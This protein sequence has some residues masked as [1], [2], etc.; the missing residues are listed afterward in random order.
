MKSKNIEYQEKIDH[1]RLF[2]A[3]LVLMFHSMVTHFLW[4]PL[5]TD[6]IHCN[7]VWDLVAEGHMA[8]GLFMT[9]SG[10]LF[11]KI[12]RDKE[13]DIP[14]FYRNRFL[15]IYPLFVFAML[16][17]CYLDQKTN[18]LLNV[19][20]SLFFM[21]NT[22]GAVTCEWLTPVLWTI[23][24][25]FQFYLLFPFLLM[26]VR[27]YGF[28]FFA[29]LLLLA[30]LTRWAVYLA[31]GSVK[32][33]AYM[34]LFGRIDEFLIGMTLGLIFDKVKGHLSH[35]LYLVLSFLSLMAAASYFHGFGGLLV[36]N[37][38]YVWIY[39]PILEGLAAGG[40]IVAYNA[41]SFRF[42]KLISKWLAFAGSLSF[43]MY[44][45]H[46]FFLRT[47]GWFMLL[48][49]FPNKNVAPLMPLITQLRIHPFSAAL[50]Y[51]ALIVLPLTVVASILTY[52]VIEKPFL[53]LRSSYTRPRKESVAIEAQEKK[54]ERIALP[55]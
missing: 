29:G 38:S 53:E 16:L 24:V 55:V 12:C 41:S 10:F 20:A 14:G 3:V 37:N 27:K 30:V 17:G 44:V 23:A 31:T 2:A 42:P 6:A 51:G 13:I 9:L 33:L 28:R 19:L 35:P 45:L 22:R 32:A 5:G 40:L 43:S 1:L 46:Y 48:V 21:Q 18:G 7:H 4:K 15:R 39:W 8:V 34:T 49:C 26:S 52:F 36:S 47:S 54:P 25:E 11:A 50:F